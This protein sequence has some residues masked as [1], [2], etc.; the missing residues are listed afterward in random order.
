MGTQMKILMVVWMILCLT[1]ISHAA[2]GIAV[3]YPNNAS[4]GK[5][6]YTP[7]KCYG[8][9]NNGV[10]VA[11]VSDALWNNGAACGRRYR[12][13]CI[14]GANEAPHPCK[15]GTSVVVKIVDYCSR[16]CQGVINLSRDAFARIADPD[17]GL[18]VARYD[19][20]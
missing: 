6:I 18:V 20:I 15:P 11:G 16:G 19:Q 2:Q 5:P 8:N 3:W 12:V 17:A 1:T 4:P 13:S 10:L 7:S 14:K 9:A